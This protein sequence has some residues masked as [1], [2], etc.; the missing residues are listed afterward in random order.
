MP[1]ASK[2]GQLPPVTA[3]TNLATVTYPVTI[4]SR[5]QKQVTESD[6]ETLYKVQDNAKETI[7]QF[8]ILLTR[9]GTHLKHG[10]KHLPVF[11]RVNKIKAP[12]ATTKKQMR[13]KLMNE[14]K[15]AGIA[16]T[17]AEEGNGDG[18]PSMLASVIGG[19]HTVMSYRSDYYKEKEPLRAGTVVRW[20]LPEFSETDTSPYTDAP[21][22]FHGASSN[23]VFALLEAVEPE[24]AEAEVRQ[25]ITDAGITTP[26]FGDALK[27][28]ALLREREI[29]TVIQDNGNGSIDI[30]LK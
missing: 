28:S 12:T 10:G 27:Y 5:S 25:A 18:T 29:G 4:A 9:K 15:F 24:N 11:S 8:S 7:E 14:L 21:V 1:R 13:Q 26:T 19:S 3:R 20:T 23:G 6:T 17:G 2:Q 22:K 30:R 16:F